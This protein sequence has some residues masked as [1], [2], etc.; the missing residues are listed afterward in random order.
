MVT[1]FGRAT[2]SWLITINNSSRNSPNNLLR[3]FN[4]PLSSYLSCNNLLFNCLSCSSNIISCFGCNSNIVSCFSYNSSFNSS[5]L[6][7]RNITS[8]NNFINNSSIFYN[9]FN[10]I[11]SKRSRGTLILLQYK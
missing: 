2:L 9:I 6:R 4:N 7:G 10:I 8:N 1:T 11:A 3:F 5:N